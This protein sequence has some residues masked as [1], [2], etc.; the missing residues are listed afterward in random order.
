MTMSR[1]AEAMP[2]KSPRVEL[3]LSASLLFA[4]GF[5][6]MFRKWLFDDFDGIFGDHGDARIVIALLE[7]WYR[8]FSGNWSDWLS[9]PFFYPERG[10][11]GFTDA[12]FLYAVGYVP[13]R[14]ASIDPFTAFMLVMAALSVIGFFGF[15]R[16]AITD[17]GVSAA[18][19]AVGAFLFAFGNMM[20]A[21]MGHAQSYC[22]MLL[23]LVAHLTATAFKAEH[24]RAAI[25]AAAAAG[26][27][28]ALIFLTAYFTGWFATLFVIVV[29]LIFAA[30]RGARAIKDGLAHVVTTKRHVLVAWIVGFAVGIV[31][32]MIVY[33]PVWLQGNWRDF[34]AIVHFAPA[35]SDIINV[36]P[37][38]WAWSWLVRAGLVGGAGQPRGELDLGFTPGV[39]FVCVLI[40]TLA[41]RSRLR[42]TSRDTESRTVVVIA[43]GLALPPAGWCS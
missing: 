8:T 11:L 5:S 23:P 32:F 29:L 28:Q 18:S 31:P 13:L 33:G 27:L 38:N 26:S 22:A 10:V 39:A 7:H 15:M 36:G 25:I 3:V 9:P 14:L 6:R 37:H 20:A 19:A 34:S 41:L 30:L 24:K 12:Y 40:T 16:L 1:P 21:K 35:F 17:F 42:T 43:L 4:F 2:T